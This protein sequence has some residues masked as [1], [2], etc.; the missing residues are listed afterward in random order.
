MCVVVGVV[1]F[2]MKSIFHTFHDFKGFQRILLKDS[3]G[4]DKI[5][6]DSLAFDGI[7]LED[8]SGFDEIL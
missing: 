6:R 2:V 8:S 4:F 7:L 1:V 5:P 3:L